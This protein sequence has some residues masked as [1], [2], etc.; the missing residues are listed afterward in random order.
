M[1]SRRSGHVVPQR[2][3]LKGHV[4]DQ[5]IVL[6]HEEDRV[7]R[8]RYPAR[9]R[10]ALERDDTEHIN[11]LVLQLQGNTGILALCRGIKD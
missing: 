10:C 9:G 7:S 4:D 3:G 5:V 2:S 6:R 8:G 1:A 11:F